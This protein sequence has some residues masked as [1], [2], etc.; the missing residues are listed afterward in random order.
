[1][2]AMQGDGNLV[3]YDAGGQSIWSSGTNAV[4]GAYV[5]LDDAGAF[6]VVSDQGVT[7]WWGVTP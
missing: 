4:P 1:M 5:S 6:R 3:L 7:V 2:L